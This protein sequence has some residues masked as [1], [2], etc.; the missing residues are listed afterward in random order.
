MIISFPIA[1]AACCQIN[2]AATSIRV[3]REIRLDLGP[4]Q[5]RDAYELQQQKGSQLLDSEVR[6]SLYSAMQVSVQLKERLANGR[7]LVFP[8]A[9]AGPLIWKL[10]H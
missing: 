10:L 3:G 5:V 1:G 9:P 2:F 7:R 8:G 6:K 4:A